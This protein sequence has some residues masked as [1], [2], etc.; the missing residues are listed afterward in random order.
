[1]IGLETPPS[2]YTQTIAITPHMS[3]TTHVLNT[4]YKPIL[5]LIKYTG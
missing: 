1:M 5:F 4:L 2:Q 3:Y